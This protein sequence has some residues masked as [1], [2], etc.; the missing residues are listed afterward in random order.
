M[1][2]LAVETKS[3]ELE[4]SLTALQKFETVQIPVVI[5][6]ISDAVHNEYVTDWKLRGHSQVKWSAHPHQKGMNNEEVC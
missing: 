5:S 3:T 2:G 6:T 1:Q 4:T